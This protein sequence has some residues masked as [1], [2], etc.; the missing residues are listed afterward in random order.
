MRYSQ[1]W[2]HHT[3][4][5]IFSVYDT[6]HERLQNTLFLLTAKKCNFVCLTLSISINVKLN[7]NFYSNNKIFICI[8]GIS[9]HFNK[10]VIRCRYFYLQNVYVSLPR[11]GSFFRTQLLFC[12]KQYFI[13]AII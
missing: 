1:P 5:N 4:Y 13:L 10:Q 8:I 11:P 3:P 9:Q 2:S 12:K 6:N 7:L